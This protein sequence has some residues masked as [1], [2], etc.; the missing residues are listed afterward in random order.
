MPRHASARLRRKR[1]PSSPTERLPAPAAARLYS[2]TLPSSPPLAMSSSSGETAT[3]ETGEACPSMRVSSG[4]PRLT[5][6]MR[7]TA[8]S[9]PVTSVVR[10]RVWVRVRGRA[11]APAGAHPVDVRAI[12]VLGAFVLQHVHRAVGPAHIDDEGLVLIARGLAR[13]CGA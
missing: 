11:V 2:T 9:L 3:H 10:E 12:H 7:T 6:Q 13:G 5:S 1:S 4:L 8:S